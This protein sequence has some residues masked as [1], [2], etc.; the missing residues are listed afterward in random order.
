D[1]DD[2][3]SEVISKLLDDTLDPT[4][5]MALA[6][7]LWVLNG[8]DKAKAK[9]VM[10]EYLKSED[11]DRRAEGALALGEI[12]DADAAKA[13]L[14]ELQAEPTERG[15]SAKFLLQV[16]QHDAVSDAAMRA[17][18][19]PPGGPT[20]TPGAWPLLDEMK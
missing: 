16:L 4:L 18:T 1:G 7:T 8:P 9:T 20:A 17:P 13:I 3:Q 15:R 11:R 5:K 19:P 2:E 10:L 14:Q 6:K 12:G